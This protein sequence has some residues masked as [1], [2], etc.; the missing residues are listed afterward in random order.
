M[1]IITHLCIYNYGILK[2]VAIGNSLDNT[3]LGNMVAMIGSSGSGKSTIADAFGFI[4]DCISTD[5]ETALNMKNRGGFDRLITQGSSGIISIALSYRSDDTRSLSYVL[6]V[7]KDA[8]NRACVSAE[9]LSLGLLPPSYD[10]MVLLRLNEGKGGVYEGEWIPK[11]K[12][13]FK[14]W[15]VPKRQANSEQGGKSLKKRKI[16]LQAF[17]FPEYVIWH[18]VLFPYDNRY[19]NKI[20]VRKGYN[21]EGRG[22]RQENWD[23]FGLSDA[24]RRSFRFAPPVWNASPFSC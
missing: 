6:S 7:G 10:K 12:I 21:S 17:W 19:D 13:P 1:G 23:G 3:E 11:G 16:P 15:R 22:A 9:T 5:V 4:A 20:I 8:Q 18:I 24:P 2:D 14:T